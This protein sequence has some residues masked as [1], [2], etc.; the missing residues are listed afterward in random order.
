MNVVAEM[1]MATQEGGGG[2]CVPFHCLDRWAFRGDGVSTIGQYSTM[3]TRNPR[4]QSQ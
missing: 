4:K 2:H 3:I 1:S